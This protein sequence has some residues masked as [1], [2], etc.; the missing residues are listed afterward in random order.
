MKQIIWN[1][2]QD[3]PVPEGYNNMRDVPVLLVIFNR[4]E[5]TRAVI[6]ALRHVKLKRLFVTA[7]GPRK[8]IRMTLKNV[9]W[10]GSLPPAWIGTVMS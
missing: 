8:T 3:Q 9:R 4:P 1:V 5:K 10:P 6:D 2:D 7:D